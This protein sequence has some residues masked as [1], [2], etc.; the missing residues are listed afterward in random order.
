[1][2][3]DETIGTINHEE[4]FNLVG[5]EALVSKDLGVEILIYLML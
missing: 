2:D 4:D 5:G 3:S 1:M